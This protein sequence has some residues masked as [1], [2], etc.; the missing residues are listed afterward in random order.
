MVEPVQNGTRK[1]SQQDQDEQDEQARQKALKELV[2]SWMDRLQLISVI[3]TFFAAIESQLLGIVTP[4]DASEVSRVQRASVAALSSSLVIHVFA[5][6]LSFIAAFFLVRF[7]LHEAS[8]QEH[9][10]EAQADHNAA[11]VRGE[12]GTSESKL[13][14]SDTAI[15]SANPQL[16]QVGPFRKGKPP[17]HLLETCH[18]LCMVFSVLGFILAL[19]GVVCYA[20]AMLPVS[21]QILCTVTIGLCLVVSTVALF[22][23]P[24]HS[25]FA[26]SHAI[27][28]ATPRQPAY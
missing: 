10:I 20:W 5:A 11:P 4:S 17:T 23:P 6:I 27:D 26:P 8:R 12:G 22:M 9:E 15:W 21:S 24:G 28:G 16:E 25:L 1:W 18:T 3:T 2:G 19:V 13:R 14:S 7:R